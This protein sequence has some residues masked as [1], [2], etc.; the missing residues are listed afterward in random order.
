MNAAAWTLHEAFGVLDFSTYRHTE[1]T[2]EHKKPANG[3]CHCNDTVDLVADLI[4]D[5]VTRVGR[6]YDVDTILYIAMQ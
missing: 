4:P 2:Y 1:T 3:G 5:K 6:A